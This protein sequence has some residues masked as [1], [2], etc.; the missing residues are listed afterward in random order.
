MMIGLSEG[1]MEENDRQ[2]WDTAGEKGEI[3]P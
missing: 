1:R 2:K 3:F